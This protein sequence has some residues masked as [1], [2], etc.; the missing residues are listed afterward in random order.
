MLE[1]CGYKVL[2]AVNGADAVKIYA[3]HAAQIK[4][5]ILDLLMPG[6]SGDKAAMELKKIN[7]EVKIILSSGM[8][9]DERASR[10]VSDSKFVFMQKP[11]TF[12]ALSR[13]VYD[14][15]DNIKKQAD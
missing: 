10:L 12:E 1:E 11:Y 13:A 3:E 15:D 2:T 5:V 8:I 6:M 9:H 4:L 7:P 14:L